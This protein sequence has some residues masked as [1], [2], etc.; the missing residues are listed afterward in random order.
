MLGVRIH[1]LSRVV[2]TP[3]GGEVALVKDANFLVTPGETVGVTGPAD[4]GG[5]ALLRLV[6]GLDPRS[7]GEVELLRRPDEPAMPDHDFGALRQELVLVASLDPLLNRGAHAALREV[8]SFSATR[9]RAVR[10]PSGPQLLDV[11]DVPPREPRAWSPAERL[12]L[13]VAL[14]WALR[15]RVLLIE[16]PA[17]CGTSAER[18]A[19]VAL[20]RRATE[21]G[22]AVI[23]ATQDERLLAALCAR[24]LLFF[25]GVVTAEGPPADV[26]P[27]ALAAWRDEEKA[28]S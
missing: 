11:A 21:Q 1:D 17:P 9:R 23:L 7:K 26:V 22:I 19:L 12:R 20:V 4:D 3:D 5:R 16:A 2:R 28:P 25:D 27:A 14:G 15:P 24:I 6:A 13:C 8:R 18:R 10:L